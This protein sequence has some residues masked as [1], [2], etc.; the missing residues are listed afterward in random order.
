LTSRAGVGWKV[1]R[2]RRWRC[3]NFGMAVNLAEIKGE[4]ER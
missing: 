2:E 1:I 3:S 4:R